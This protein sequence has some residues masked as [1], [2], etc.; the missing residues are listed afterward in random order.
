MEVYI[1]ATLEVIRQ[2]T[3]DRIRSS[4]RLG[5]IGAGGALQT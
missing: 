4:G 3:P 5:L 2:D 1:P